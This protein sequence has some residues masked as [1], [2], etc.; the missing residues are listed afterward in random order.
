MIQAIQYR[1]KNQVYI[2]GS[3]LLKTTDNIF[4]RLSSLIPKVPTVRLIMEHKVGIKSDYK[5]Y[6]KYGF[7]NSLL[8]LL[9][10]SK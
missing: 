1:H 10:I 8:I 9:V 7:K 4:S 6:R 3:Y 5:N 2:G